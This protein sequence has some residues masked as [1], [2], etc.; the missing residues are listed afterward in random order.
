M[1]NLY[2]SLMSLL[3][4]LSVSAA[5]AASPIRLK[6]GEVDTTARIS[7]TAAAT[8]YAAEDVKRVYLIQCQDP[9]SPAWREAIER[10][11]GKIL[12]Y[13]PENAY[14]VAANGEVAA[15]IASQVPYA[16]FGDYR[17][18][19]KVSTSVKDVLSRAAALKMSSSDASFKASAYAG[20]FLL[21]IFPFAEASDV[22]EKISELDGCVVIEANG[23]VVR[24]KL[25][26]SAVTKILSWPEIEWLEPYIEKELSNNVAV[27]SSRM[28]VTPVWPSGTSGLGLTGK[29]QVVAVCDTGLDTGNTSTLHEDVRGR[30]TRTYCYGRSNN[31]SDPDGHGTHVVGSV[32][33]NGTKSSGTFKGVAYEASLIL[34]SHMTSAGGICLPSDLKTLFK[35]AYD[36]VSGTAGARIHSNSWGSG[37]QSYYPE[38]LGA[39]IAET[40]AVDQFMFEHPDMLIFFA[41]GNEGIDSDR[42]GVIDSDSICSEGTA[43]NCMTVGA[44]ENDRTSGGYSQ[45]TWGQASPYDYP[46]APIKG[47]KISGGNGMAAFSSRGPC[48]DGRIKPDIVAP[49]TDVVS[50]RSS[51][52]VPKDEYDYI[53]WGA[54]NSYYAYM[55]GTSMATPLTAGAAAL[56]R[57]WLIEKQKISQPDGS[58]VKAVMLAGAKSLA[59]GQYTTKVEVPSS[60]PNN[61]EG[62]GQVNLR[63]SLANT[64]G[65]AVFDGKVIGHGETQEYKVSVSSAGTPL[66]IVMAYTDAPAL[67]SSEAQLV[68]DLDLTVTT[69]SGATLY[70]NSRTSPD[71]VNNVEGVR[72]ASAQKGVYT[73]KV[74]AYSIKSPMSTTWTG[75]KANATRYSVAV[76]GATQTAALQVSDC[77]LSNRATTLGAASAVS[78]FNRGE[79]V[80]A[81]GRIGN[82][83]SVDYKDGFSI[84]HELLSGAVSKGDLAK[85]YTE[86][87]PANGHYDVAAFYWN[88]LQN[89]AVG[90]YTYRLTLT[91]AGAEPVQSTFSFT[92]VEPPSPLYAVEI[93]GAS[94]VGGGS[95]TTY[96]CRAMLQDGTVVTAAP[97]WTMDSGAAFASLEQ[98]GVLNAY[99]TSLPRTVV[100]RASCTYNGVTRSGTKTV[101][102]KPVLTLNE[103][104]DCPDWTLRS[105]GD[106]EWFGQTGRTHDNVDAAQ[107]GAIADGQ[108]SYFETTVTGPGTLS[109]WYS[110]STEVH[111]DELVVYV[112]GDWRFKAS[113]SIDWQQYSIVFPGGDHVVKFA[114]EKDV[115]GSDGDDAVYL[116]QLTWTSQ[117]TPEALTITGDGTVAAGSTLQ[118]G[119]TATMSDGSMRT[120]TD[121]GCTWSIASGSA[122]AEISTLTGLLTAKPSAVDRSVTVH[123]SYEAG[124]VT[125]STTRTILI[126]G[127]EPMPSA[128]I[129]TRSGEGD[130]SAAV[131]GWSAADNASSYRVYRSTGTTRPSSAYAT[132]GKVLSYRDTNAS[133]GVEY[134]YWVSAVNTSGE[135]SSARAVAHRAVQLTVT[136]DAVSFEATG[137]TT[138]I[139]VKSNVS[140]VSSETSATWLSAV[141]TS[142]SLTILAEPNTSE[143]SRTA[144]VTLTAAGATAH[145]A[146]TVV[147]VFQSGV[148]TPTG[149]PDF[150]FAIFDQNWDADYALYAA[151]TAEADKACRLFDNGKAIHLRYGWGNFGD[152]A[153]VGIVTNVI[154]VGRRHENVKSDSVDERD[155]ELDVLTRH[156]QVEEVEMEPGFAEADTYTA[157]EWKSLKPGVYIAKVMLNESEAMEETDYYNNDL[158][159]R[160]AVRDSVTLPTALDCEDS[161]LVVSAE[162]EQWYGTAGLGYDGE[163]CAMT[164]L[165]GDGSTDVLTATVSGAGTLSFIYKVATEATYD[166]L[167]FKDGDTELLK[168]SGIGEWKQVSFDIAAG[169]HTFTWTYAKDSIGSD[170]DDCVYLDKL[171]WTPVRVGEAPSDFTA[172][173][174]IANYVLLTWTAVSDAKSYVIERASHGGE[175]WKEIYAGTSRK[176]FDEDTLGGVIY[177]Y[178]IKSV[179]ADGESGWSEVKS[180]YRNAYVNS[181]A[182]RWIPAANGM[183]GFTITPNGRWTAESDVTW[184]KID[185]A[186]GSNACKFVYRYEANTG[187]KQRS[188]KITLTVGEPDNGTKAAGYWTTKTIMV[189]QNPALNTGGTLPLSEAADTTLQLITSKDYP[190]IGQ[191][192]ISHDGVA[193]IRSGEIGQSAT[194]RVETVV[195]TG[196]ELTFWWGSSSGTNDK[197]TFYVNGVKQGSISGY[198]N[199][200][201]GKTNC[202]NWAFVTVDVPEAGA[203]LAWE[204]VRENQNGFAEDAAFVD[205]ITWT[206][207]ER[208]VSPEDAWFQKYYPD[209]FEQLGVTWENR[210]TMLTMPSP[211]TDKRGKRHSDGTVI[212]VRDDYAAGTNPL[213]SDDLFRANITIVNGVPK[214]SWTPVLEPAEAVLRNYQIHG[215]KSLS[216]GSWQPVAEG[217]E[218]EYQFFK[219]SVEVQ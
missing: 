81:Y 20:E 93:I 35:T 150:T 23:D 49:G 153:A 180:G 15:A 33:G 149:V 129:I 85:T 187:D 16:Y 31:W 148:E 156:E 205:Q 65:V 135:T 36:T 212:C 147:T 128:P 107:S 125:K 57:Q 163:D 151:E 37:N 154:E 134:S 201:A 218:S 21:S 8:L 168:D 80:Y 124:G 100:I 73:I 211:G 183:D 198:S 106:A 202:T 82:P 120:V 119:C 7:N 83:G 110:V 138:N 200:T 55:G 70:P 184:L 98:S 137:G 76:N 96:T 113:G 12:G 175:D 142:S 84:K 32:V 121:S 177:D 179:Y 176:V 2:K 68:N 61:V 207:Q 24:A 166:V 42:D 127:V 152:G 189:Y 167:M 191:R 158:A 92:V 74:N 5:V 140:S 47:D 210:K 72:I 117:L 174:T 214:V 41:A 190:W 78:T 18:E 209:L 91:T 87:I 143:E 123:A 165:A 4:A 159:F 171:V 10:A 206:P 88:G 131:L 69:P 40:R 195:A 19:Y 126:T 203:V 144:L 162:S 71:R 133:P 94:T 45:Y 219:V 52:W 155:I 188:A 64:A 173:T 38:Y 112:D 139:A 89:L 50:M 146:E 86:T 122:Y 172:S 136:Q 29:G 170:G 75:G 193:S 217:H 67:L 54:Y 178:R 157:T 115:N 160:F 95:K 185:T 97:V 11:G 141:C 79:T 194:S 102:I 161:A 28:N 30:V 208:E 17:P 182:M 145:P 114:Y 46:T 199:T 213:D 130:H 44:S 48:D 26:E 22:A 66:A 186:S 58:T 101:A 77:F 39:Y 197:L 111:C 53:G 60:Y 3:T 109:F 108:T 132:L 1:K 196:G 51:V 192:R 169:D 6:S 105:G 13:V 43:K 90:S 103:A 164:K 63:N 62:W 104:L 56:V 216:A 59:P 116:D 34:Q 9:V 27:G 215:R 118:L 181:P 204:Y 25:S 14:L 99:A